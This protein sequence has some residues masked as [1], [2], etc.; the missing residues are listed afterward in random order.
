LTLGGES[1]I[2][3]WHLFLFS[4]FENFDE[5]GNVRNL[6]AVFSHL[7]LAVVKFGVA[8]ASF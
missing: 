5:K 3:C 2:I 8:K 7:D 6:K 1:G 4:L